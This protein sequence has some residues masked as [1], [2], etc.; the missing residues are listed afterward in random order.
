MSCEKQELFLKCFR[1]LLEL[2]STDL[3]VSLALK[4]IV[5]KVIRAFEI[6]W[7]FSNS[8]VTSSFG[9]ERRFTIVSFKKL[10]NYWSLT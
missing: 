4:R 9:Q 5:N 10:V 8:Q 3:N 6:T 7:F 2:L 1:L